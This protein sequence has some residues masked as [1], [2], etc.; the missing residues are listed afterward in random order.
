MPKG[1]TMKL[2][3]SVAIG[4][5]P[6]L[7][8][9]CQEIPGESLRIT[10]RDSAG[11]TIVENRGAPPEAGPWALGP[12]PDLTIGALDGQAENQLWDVAGATVLSDGRLAVINRGTLEVRLYRGDG[13]FLRAFGGK[14]EGPGEFS[15]MELAGTL[16]GDTLVLS[17]LDLRRITLIHPDVGFVRSAAISEDLLRWNWT[18]G[19]I[20]NS[21]MRGGMERY[22]LSTHPEGRRGMER[23][24]TSFQTATLTGALEVDFGTFPFREIF[25]DMGTINGHETSVAFDVPFGM[26]ASFAVGETRFFFGPGDRYEIKVFDSE[27][28]LQRIIRWNRPLLPVTSHHLDALLERKVAGAGDDQEA[29]EISQEFRDTPA[30]SHLPAYLGFEVDRLGSLWVR[31]YPE[32]PEEPQTYHIFDRQGHLVGRV[33]IPQGMTVL[34][35]GADY[36]LTLVKDEM[37]VEYLHRYG[38][39]RSRDKDSPEPSSEKGRNY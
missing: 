6:I 21:I 17:D 11:I 28:H 20:G 24:P 19:L 27:T 13:Q 22:E 32:F 35:I 36:L 10:L 2:L 33:G 31:D 29:R 8:A 12:L 37:G 34:E 38:L 26:E 30:A 16:P 4:I 9:A 25:Y 23:V 18:V 14:G 39:V 15:Y 3:P 5:F 7:L 1:D